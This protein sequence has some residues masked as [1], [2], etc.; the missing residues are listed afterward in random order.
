MRNR[1]VIALALAAI[2]A[3]VGHAQEAE[4]AAHASGYSLGLL[5]G[6]LETD[7]IIASQYDGFGTML[8]DGEMVEVPRYRASIRWDMPG[9]RVDYDLGVG[10]QQQR[11]GEVFAGEYAWDEDKPGA[12]LTPTSGTATSAPDTYEERLLQMWVTP[13]GAAKAAKA[14]ADEATLTTVNDRPVLTFSLPAPL[15]DTVMTL[16]LNGQT[17]RPE[18]VQVQTPGGLLEATFSGYTDFDLSDT[19]YPARVTHTLDGETILDLTLNAGWGYNPYVIFPIP[20]SVSAGPPGRIG[21]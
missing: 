7:Y 3:G 5:R 18:M 17:A 10:A 11:K 9:M 20:E 6:L 12:G 1:L 16:T 14:A 21:R 4:E 15:Q 19:V 8:V 13:Q 2:L